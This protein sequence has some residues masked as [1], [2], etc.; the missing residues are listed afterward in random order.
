MRIAAG[1]PTFFQALGWFLAHPENELVILRGN[2]DIETVW[3]DVQEAVRSTISASYY[4]WYRDMI[5]GRIP[6]LVIDA[7]EDSHQ[8]TG[9]ML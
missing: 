1:H 6:D 3:P 9:P 5:D 7:I 8:V 4:A 2:H